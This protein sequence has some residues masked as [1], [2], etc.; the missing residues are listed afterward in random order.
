MSIRMDTIY[1]KLKRHVKFSG[2]VIM[3]LN[4]YQDVF[5]VAIVVAY[6][7]RRILL[8]SMTIP[9]PSALCKYLYVEYP[10]QGR[11][12]GLRGQVR[13]DIK[14]CDLELYFRLS[15]YFIGDIRMLEK[16]RRK[17]RVI[18][19]YVLRLSNKSFRIAVRNG[20]L[21]MCVDKNI[22]CLSRLLTLFP[23]IG[24]FYQFLYMCMICGQRIR[25][26]STLL[27]L[28][29]KLSQKKNNKR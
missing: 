2:D 28:S 8:S 11:L 10:S 15:Y 7:S 14:L 27:C 9:S 18:F 29:G 24:I 13:S 1:R 25:I 5:M 21:K 19:L 16:V 20:I 3:I 12:V 22:E 4:V 23:T 17:R 6:E 26:R